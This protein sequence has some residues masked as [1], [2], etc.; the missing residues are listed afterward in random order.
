M[1]KIN[2]EE[3]YAQ[4]MVKLDGLMTKGSENVSK[5]ELEEIRYLAELAQEYEQSTMFQSP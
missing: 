5:E 3:E 2:S 1:K 4:I